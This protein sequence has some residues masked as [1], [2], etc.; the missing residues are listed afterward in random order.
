[1]VAGN[2]NYRRAETPLNLQTF[3]NNEIDDN[4][5][6]IIANEGSLIF[7]TVVLADGSDDNSIVD[8]NR[9]LFASAGQDIV[10]ANL[11]IQNVRDSDVTTIS[12]RKMKSFTHYLELLAARSFNKIM[13]QRLMLF[14]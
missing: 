14:V 7:E 9:N 2:T 3:G 5:A 4:P 10:N 11:Y 6:V 13:L 12:C 8:I 1:M